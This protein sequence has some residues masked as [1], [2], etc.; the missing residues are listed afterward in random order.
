MGQGGLG[1]PTKTSKGLVMP[2]CAYVSKSYLG[3]S[4]APPTH[5][6]KASSVLTRMT[7]PLE[8]ACAIWLLVWCWWGP[9]LALP[10]LALYWGWCGVG[11]FG[12]N[13]ECFLGTCRLSETKSISI[14]LVAIVKKHQNAD[15]LAH[16]HQASLLGGTIEGLMGCH[17]FS[18]LPLGI[19]LGIDANLFG[20]G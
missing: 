3:S 10:A 4:V 7:I 19:P 8:L 20:F 9:A 13:V 2:S 15:A 1:K 12:S 11:A 14:T 6:Y 5:L 18:Q 16:T 17:R